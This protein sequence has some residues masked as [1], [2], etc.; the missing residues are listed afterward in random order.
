MKS[1]IPTLTIIG[2]LFAVAALILSISAIV[3][4]NKKNCPEFDKF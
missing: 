3:Q 1:I 4:I 2:F